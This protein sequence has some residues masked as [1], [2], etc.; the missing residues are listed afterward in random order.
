M[1]L[2]IL[3]DLLRGED[4]RSSLHDTSAAGVCVCVC[5]CV[6]LSVCVCMCPAAHLSQLLLHIPLYLSF[7]CTYYY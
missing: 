1:G 2:N 4:G 5:V 3:T 7:H 6:C